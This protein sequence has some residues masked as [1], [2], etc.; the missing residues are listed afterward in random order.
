MRL[1]ALLYL[2]RFCLFGLNTNSYKCE[3]E[4][5]LRFNLWFLTVFH[6]VMSLIE[7]ATIY[8][9]AQGTI[10][11]PSP[12]KNI[13][14][15]LYAEAIVFIVK[16]VLEIFCFLWAVDPSCDCPDSNMIV[17]LACYILVYN[18][19]TTVAIALYVQI[20]RLPCMRGDETRHKKLGEVKPTVSSHG[21]LALSSEKMK[22]RR[23]RGRVWQTRIR[24]LCC[25]VRL[26]ER[27]K[28]VYADIGRVMADSFTYLKGYVLSDLAAGMA[29]MAMKQKAKCNVSPNHSYYVVRLKDFRFN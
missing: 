9:S 21:L 11:N 10:A 2:C 20:C 3:N 15:V 12:R 19:I 29:L 5:I 24:W 6:I 13:N 28:S 25:C 14:I 18:L 7:V 16:F 4:D 22:E 26:R 23:L 17:L 8:I 27:N 1:L